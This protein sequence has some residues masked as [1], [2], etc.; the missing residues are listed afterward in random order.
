M[1]VQYNI[2]YQ[3]GV[4]LVRAY[5]LTDWK[6]ILGGIRLVANELQQNNKLLRLTMPIYHYYNLSVRQTHCYLL[7][8]NNYNNANY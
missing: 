8:T 2:A 3:S 5:V 6:Q 1:S 4:C 7:L